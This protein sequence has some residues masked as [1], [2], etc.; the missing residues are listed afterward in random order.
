MRT[1]QRKE[2]V[3][4]ATSLTGKGQLYIP[5]IEDVLVE[6]DDGAAQEDP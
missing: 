1:S 4:S 6:Y 5:R 3:E 2:E